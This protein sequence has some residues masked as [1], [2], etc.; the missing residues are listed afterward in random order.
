MS[1][2]VTTGATTAVLLHFDSASKVVKEHFM[3]ASNVFD[4]TIMSEFK[5]AA[6]E[7][8]NPP[9]GPTSSGSG[10]SSPFASPDFGSVAEDLFFSEA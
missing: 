3:L 6:A 7:F 5:K 8:K 4:D 2:G 1:S 10:S 9:M